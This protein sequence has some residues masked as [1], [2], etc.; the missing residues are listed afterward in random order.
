MQR[1]CIGFT[2]AV[3]GG[4]CARCTLYSDNLLAGPIWGACEEEGSPGMSPVTRALHEPK[5]RV[6]LG[7]GCA[8][9]HQ[10]LG[11]ATGSGPGQAL[12]RGG[13][14]GRAGATRG[15]ASSLRAPQN[16]PP[17]LPAYLPARLAPLLWP[18]RLPASFFFSVKFR[19]LPLSFGNFP[20][21]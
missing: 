21:F 6:Q 9:P 2:L 20:S 16:G 10:R 11:L 5:R 18:T 13:K 15:L 8:R 14:D 3:G 17:P 12:G 7:H 19:G 4:I 1:L